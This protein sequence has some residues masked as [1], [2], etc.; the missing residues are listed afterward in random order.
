MAA[1][2]FP[3]NPSDSQIFT[4]S[5]G[6]TYVY[7]G[8]S[9]YWG[10]QVTGGA[11]AVSVGDTAPSNPI[12]GQ[13]WFNS[14]TLRTYI[15]YNNQWIISNPIGLQGSTGTAGA[16]GDNITIYATVPDLPTENGTGDLAYVSGTSTL[17]IWDGTSWV[18]V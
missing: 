8:S 3:V 9:G 16:D 6:T 11:G 4:A 10:V 2:V 7:N 1:I 17:Y 15:Y 13:Q 12:Q 5:N 18:A 14:T